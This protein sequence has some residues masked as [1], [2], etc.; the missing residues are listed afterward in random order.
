M[1]QLNTN[2]FGHT[3]VT[4]ALLPHFRLRKEGKI[5]F[6]SSIFSWIG[7]VACTPYAVSKHALSAYAT[8]LQKEVGQFGIQTVQFDIGFFRTKFQTSDNMQ[9]KP[10]VFDDYKP[11]VEAFLPFISTMNG[12]QPGD[13]RKGVQRMIDVLTQEGMAKGKKIPE[14]LP[15]GPDGLATVREYCKKM[16]E[17]CEEWEDLISS[18]D[19]DG[20]KE[21][22]WALQSGTTLDFDF[23]GKT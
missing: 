3:Y 23:T 7:Q 14:R 19:R 15:L 12:Y 13:V 16:L 22:A 1:A 5:A 4:Q 8:T 18:T 20:P 17:T 10:P 6:I 9:F 21:G 2:F 11:T